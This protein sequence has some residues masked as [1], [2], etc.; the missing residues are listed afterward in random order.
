MKVFIDTNVLISAALFPGSVP[1][2]AFVKAVSEPFE[3]MVCDQNIDELRRIFRR[4]FPGKQQALD[5]FFSIIMT[6]VT[7]VR[8]PEQE[9]PD[10]AKIRDEKDR[11]IFRAALG[12]GADLFLTGDKDF[13]ESGITD[14]RIITPGGFMEM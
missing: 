8:V 12:N 3:A 5:T 7:I 9:V 2:K 10:E 14:P 1:Y 4:K 6:S 13:L 11:P